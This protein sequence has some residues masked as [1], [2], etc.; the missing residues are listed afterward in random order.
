MAIEVSAGVTVKAVDPLIEPDVAVIVVDPA[1]T[2]VASPLLA[3]V[4][5]PGFDELQ[6]AVAVRLLVVPFE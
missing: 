6:V 3:I 5:A 4:A 2:P 1:A